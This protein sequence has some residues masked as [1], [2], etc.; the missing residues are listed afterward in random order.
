L[1]GT[2]SAVVQGPAL[3]HS[4]ARSAARAGSSFR[5]DIALAQAAR[6]QRLASARLAYEAL[7][8]D[9]VGRHMA[10]MPLSRIKETTQGRLRLGAIEKAGFRTVGAVAAAGPYRLR[11]IPG[12]GPQ[13]AAHVIA[14]AHQLQTMM[15]QE[16][17]IRFDPDGRTEPQ[18]VLLGELREYEVAKNQL[19]AS[20]AGARR[21]TDELDAVLKGAARAS[22]RLRMFFSGP[23]KKQASRDDLDRLR[24]LMASPDAGSLQ[25]RLDEILRQ[26]RLDSAR[27]WEDYQARAV[28]YNGLLIEISGLATDKEASQGFLP[29][30]LARRVHEHPLD[31]SLMKVSLRG[32]Q[33]FGAKF[34]L[35]Q[36]RAIIGDE[37][38]LGKTVQ[39]LAAACHLYSQDQR[40]SLV[41]CPASVLINWTREV[42]RHT[43]LEA[44]RLHGPNRDANYLVWARR[45]GIA[46]TTYE[47]L[48]GLGT[49][50]SQ[51]DGPALAMLIVDEAHYAK[52]PEAART[53]AVCAWASRT[54]RVV[55]LTG[56]PMQ[57]NVE[58]FR[59]LVSHLHP[60]LASTMVPANGVLSSTRFRQAVAPVYLRRNQDDVLTELPPRLDTQEWVELD[61]ADLRAYREAVFA[62]NFM[63]MRR[64]AYAPGT[65][66]GSA[67]LRRLAELVEE[68]TANDRKVVVFSY[69]RDV[70][71][72]VTGMIGWRAIGPLT[73]SVTVSARQGMIDEFSSRKE[74][75]VLVSQIQAGGVGLNIQAASVVILA[76]PQWSPAVEDQAIARCH[77]LGQVRRVDVYRILA[78]NSVDQRMLEII[79]T[80]AHLFDE[81]ARR[82]DLKDMTP[83]AVDVSDLDTTRE[84]ATQAE[85]ERRI[86]EMERKRLRMESP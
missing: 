23:G 51:P 73:G 76:E 19:P 4:A 35:A 82:S 54:G 46:V 86:L 33:A 85:A 18:T 61:G 34:A 69:F 37:M 74:P 42:R 7:R 81:Y 1:T 9:V 77:R 28:A 24:A 8:R 29:N 11:S 79:S 41:V 65:P 80:K 31:L 84:T 60:R 30:E 27:L 43:R 17:R 6:A 62:G 49:P 64:A 3:D 10:T 59:A 13:T 36:Q 32:Y 12:V 15:E 75:A 5:A 45:G 38:G 48:R 70:L 68:A 71:Q 63:A 22:S 20:D 2:Q 21:I 44:Y 72:T 55:F 67:K 53:K 50:D 57:N 52:N 39:A 78:E 14:A 47:T 66:A 56:T 40:H 58:E 25:R 16:T 83:D 26:P